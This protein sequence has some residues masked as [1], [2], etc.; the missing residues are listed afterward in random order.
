MADQVSP[1]ARPEPVEK[2]IQ[3]ISAEL[4]RRREQPET[5]SLSGHELV[6]QTVRSY[7]GVQPT[8]KQAEPAQPAG[9]TIDN[10]LPGYAESAPPEA[11]RE[12]EQY[13]QMAFKDGILKASSEAAKA[14]PFVLDAFHDALAGKLYEELKKRGVVE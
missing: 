11:K 12:I 2:D 3:R 7:T 9:E 5:R 14:S 6:R 4:L 8:A 1:E 10:P 13:L